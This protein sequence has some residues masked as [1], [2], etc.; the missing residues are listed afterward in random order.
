[1]V[2]IFIFKKFSTVVKV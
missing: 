2:L 1:M